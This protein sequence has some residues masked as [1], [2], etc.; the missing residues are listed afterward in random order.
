MV[1]TKTH[2]LTGHKGAIY[3]IISTS[4]NVFISG[5]SDGYVCLW[6]IDKTSDGRVLLNANE[7]IFSLALNADKNLLAVGTMNGNLHLFDVTKKELIKSISA[8]QK[9]VY[10]VYHNENTLATA[11][12]DGALTFWNTQNYLP[13]E[14]LILSSK[15]L[16]SIAASADKKH[17]YI[18]ASDSNFFVVDAFNHNVIATIEAHEN[19]V[20]C[21]QQNSIT[22]EIWTGSRDAHLKIWAADGFLLRQAVPAHI[23]TINDIAFSPDGGLAATASRDKTI[24]IWHTT[25]YELLKVI[26]YSKY[27]AH[28]N[29]V[30]KVIWLDAI[31]IAS[32]SDDSTILLFRVER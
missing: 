16:R 13:T 31:T 8:H 26:D 18:S 6:D 25:T 2:T 22:Q 12:G 3:S 29:S 27:S 20:F 11:G 1:V 14:T 7:T 21:V 32:C 30:N 24:K 19:S 5:G 15:A 23:A 10:A 4:D 17:L 9:C 28:K